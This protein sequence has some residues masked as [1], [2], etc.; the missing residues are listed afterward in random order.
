VAKRASLNAAA[1]EDA[2][3]VL[4]GVRGRDIGRASLPASRAWTQVASAAWWRLLRGP[5]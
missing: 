2:R 5:R 3:Q 1:D 4:R